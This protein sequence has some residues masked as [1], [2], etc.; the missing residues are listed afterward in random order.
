MK[1]VN[2][3]SKTIIWGFLAIAA[4]ACLIYCSIIINNAKFILH[5]NKYVEIDTS[6]LQEARYQ[7]SYAI[8][9]I[10][11]SIVLIGIG[12]YITYAGIKSWNYKA[13]L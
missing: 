7:M 11:I 8:A 9:G 4:L 2:I 12:S 3:H 10:A 5:V 1:K 13:I 6:L